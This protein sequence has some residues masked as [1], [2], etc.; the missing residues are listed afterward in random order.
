MGKDTI[1]ILIVDDQV[2]VRR[3]LFEALSDEGYLVKMA[4]GGAEALSIIAQTTPSVILLDMK[5]PGLTGFETL[6][7]IRK[8]YGQLPV[9]MM[10]AYGDLEIVNQTKG[11]G[12]KHYLN[13]PFDLDDVRNLARL[14]ISKTKASAEFQQ[15]IG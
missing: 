6:Q 1:D 10:T 5:M 12:V 2:G 4:A 3:L 8:Q 9:I 11:L 7:E 13:K 15:G 14:V